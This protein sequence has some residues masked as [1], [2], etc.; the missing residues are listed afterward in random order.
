VD[1]PWVILLKFIVKLS[2]RE[3]WEKRKYGGKL[4]IFTPAKQSE[5]EPRSEYS[6]DNCKAERYILGSPIPNRNGYPYM[7]SARLSWPKDVWPFMDVIHFCAPWRHAAPIYLK[8]H[9]AVSLVEDAMHVANKRKRYNPIFQVLRIIEVEAHSWG[10]PV[11]SW[12]LITIVSIDRNRRSAGSEIENF[13]YFLSIIIELCACS[14]SAVNSFDRGSCLQP[15]PYDQE[16]WATDGYV[17]LSLMRN[18]YILMAVTA[19]SLIIP[20][21][22]ELD[23][24]RVWS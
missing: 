3:G 6:S 10:Y 20:W 8:A 15:L 17:Q 11:R 23:A 19:R 4:A 18:N 9:P 2:V 21:R 22:Y 13:K 24:R 7:A 14:A 12:W 16:R 1:L 5:Q